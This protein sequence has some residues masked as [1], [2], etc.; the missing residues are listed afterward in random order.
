MCISFLFTA[1]DVNKTLYVYNKCRLYPSFW[2]ISRAEGETNH[3][4]R[5]YITRLLTSKRS[6]HYCHVSTNRHLKRV[7]NLPPENY[8]IPNGI[9]K[10]YINDIFTGWIG[11][12]V[13]QDALTCIFTYDKTCPLSYDFFTIHLFVIIHSTF[14]PNHTSNSTWFV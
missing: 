4:K 3:S 13:M 1:S 14:F 11:W 10:L 5:R 2:V 9:A 12:A 7:C 8:F 6:L